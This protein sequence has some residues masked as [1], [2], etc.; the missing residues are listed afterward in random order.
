MPL[1]ENWEM[2]SL[3]QLCC[4]VVVNAHTKR[5][6]GLFLLLPND[7]ADLCPQ[8]WRVMSDLH[9]KQAV[10]QVSGRDLVME[11]KL[12]RPVQV[13]L[14]EQALSGEEV[15]VPRHHGGLRCLQVLARQYE[16]RGWARL[17]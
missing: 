15:S 1:F 8:S 6:K 10:A 3:S 13:P 11:S 4:E 12:S 2:D 16:G 9:L 5:R 14:G 7:H 17:R